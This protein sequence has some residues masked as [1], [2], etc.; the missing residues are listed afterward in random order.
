MLP[1]IIVATAGFELVKVIGKSVRVL[2]MV[3]AKSVVVYTFEPN[4]PRVN[5]GAVIVKVEVAS[6][7]SVVVPV[8]PPP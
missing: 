7:G 4:E 3:G 2:V 1:F 5:V 6:G 8:E